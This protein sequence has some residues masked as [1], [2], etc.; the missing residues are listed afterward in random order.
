MVDWDQSVMDVCVT[1]RGQKV[2][3]PKVN[4]HAKEFPKREVSPGNKGCQ[5][6]WEKENL[7]HKDVVNELWKIQEVEDKP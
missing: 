2:R 6:K 3:M 4:M 5:I 1:R 7:I